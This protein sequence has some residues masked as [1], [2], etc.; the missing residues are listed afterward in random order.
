[1]RVPDVH[2]LQVRLAVDAVDL[3]RARRYQAERYVELD[4]ASELVDGVIEDPFVAHSDYFLA[5][6]GDNDDLVGTCR[7]IHGSDAGWPTLHTLDL[8]PA[9]AGSLAEVPV[10][11]MY[12]IGALVTDARKA[13]RFAISAHLYREVPRNLERHPTEAHIIAMMD[14]RLLRAMNRFFHFPFHAIGPESVYHGGPVVPA[15]GYVPDQLETVVRTEGAD[16]DFMLDGRTRHDIEALADS[17]RAASPPAAAMAD[18]Y[19]AGDAD[20]QGLV[21]SGRVS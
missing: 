20:G 16:F 11:D 10:A 14:P 17:L 2:G 13:E 7:F 5:T 21:R 18:V 8:F 19:A 3:A 4:F 15:Y 9:W 1:M 6:A 12:E